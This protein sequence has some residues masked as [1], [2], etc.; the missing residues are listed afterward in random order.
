MKVKQDY[1]FTSESV[2]EGHPDKICDIIS[3]A[4]LDKALSEDP[5]SRV[6]CECFTSTGLVLVGGE[7]TTTSYIDIIQTAREVLKDIGYTEPEDG[8]DN[9]S[10]SVISVIKPQSQDISQGVTA[11]EGLHREQGAGDQG[12]MFGYACRQTE[13]LMPAPIQFS[14][15]IMKK[16]ADVRKDGTLNFLRPDG[17]CQVTVR[18]KDGKPAHIDTVVLS[19]QHRPDIDH[20]TLSEALIETVIKPALPRELLS[21]KTVYHINPTGRFVIGGPLGDAGL[22]GRKIIVDTYG[23]YSRHGGGAFSGKDPSKV[24]RSAAYMARYMAKN[25]VASGA[26][27]EA[28]VQLAYAIGIAEPVSLYINTFGTG[29]IDENRLENV[30]RE[31]F[32][33][34]PAGII[35]SLNLKRPIYRPTAAYGHF[36]RPEFP[37][38]KTDKADQIKAALS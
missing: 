28:E 24:D 7:I 27:D 19:H 3:D 5:E 36:G 17:K 1:I 14:H 33:L 2:G 38:E 23:G 13:E 22:T 25:I 16:A 26:A 20:K 32:D 10:C 18:Y 30:L 11:G 21:G 8:I 37:W 6:A 35:E 4:V 31:V 34:T 29:R 9:I 15:S 12:L